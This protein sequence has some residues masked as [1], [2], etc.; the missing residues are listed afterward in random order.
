MPANP[1]FDDIVTTTLRNRSGKLADNAT[2]TMALLDRLRRKGKVKPADGG[3]TIVQEL[4]VALNPN[5]GWYAG[6]DVLNA[7][8]FEPFSAAEYDWK[9][10]YVPAVWSGLDKLRNQGEMATINLVSARIKNSEKSLMDLVAQ[11]SYADGTGYG[12][13]QM[14]GLGLFVVASPGSGIVGGIDRGGNT[15]WRN[16]TASVTVSGAG[17][18][19]NIAASNPSNYLTALNGL[20]IACTRGTD[21]P[22]L[23]VA[24][25]TAYQRYLESLQPLQRIT[26]TDMAGFGFTALKYF[27]VGGNADFVLDN[28]Y[29]PATTTFALNTDFIYLRPHPDRDFVPFGGDRIPVQQDATVRYVGFTGNM[30][31]S[32]LFLQGQLHSNN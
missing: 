11:A 22:D 26:N 9:Q 4:E 13:K 30:T 10:A 31:A 16:Q 21:R 14:G 17:G 2:R 5:G 6:L 15:F 1:N 29:C 20:S 18:V 23:Y 27:G 25:A 8:M 7:N 32:N 28:G 12:G 3:R 19:V 24:G